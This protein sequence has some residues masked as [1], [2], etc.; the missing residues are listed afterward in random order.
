MARQLTARRPPSAVRRLPPAAM[1]PD[2]DDDDDDDDDGDG[3]GNGDGG[4]DDI[5]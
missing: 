4:G 5:L 1:S 2:G 3:D